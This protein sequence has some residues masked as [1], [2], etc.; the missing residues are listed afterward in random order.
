MAATD[1]TSSQLEELLGDDAE[2]PAGP[3]L[4]DHRQVPALPAGPRLPGPHLRGQRPLHADHPQPP[5]A[6]RQ[7]PPGRH[8]LREHPARSTRAS[9]TRAAPASAPTRPTSTPRTWSS[10]RSRA[11][12]TPWPPPSGVLGAVSRKYA[13]KIPFIVK[14]NHNELLTY[15]NTFDQVMFGSVQRAYDL[16]AAGVGATIYFGSEQSRRQLVEIVAGLRGG[17][18]RWACSPC[19][20]ATCATTTS[21]T[22]APTTTLAADL[23]GQ[24][25]H[26]GVTI[27]A[28][29]IKQKLPE[30][31]GGFERHRAYG[32]TNAAMYDK[33]THR[34]PD[35]PDPLPAGQLLHGPHRADQQ[36]RRVLGRERP[37]RGRA[38]RRDQQARRRHG[39]DLGPQGLPAADRR[40]HR[41]CST[42]SRTCTSIRTSN[43][44][45]YWPRKRMSTL[46]S[47]ARR[48]LA[49]SLAVAIQL[50][51]A[52]QLPAHGDADEH[53]DAVLLGQQR[54]QRDDRAPPRWG[55]PRR[56]AR[57]RRGPRRTSR[58]RAG[59]RPGSAAARAP[60]P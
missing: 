12:A 58:R 2:R 41:A 30:N 13:H 26:L 43:S 31:N 32:K 19:S 7:R 51:L 48:K 53:A 42:R 46:F 23:T 8:R 29:I 18:P 25:N 1:T 17:P 20:G 38:H 3:H 56:C 59:P 34:Q 37:G 54:A 6:G 16:G 35:R 24:A 14:L 10:W 45:Q 11:A 47:S 52:R 57:W 33:L 27:E 15:P 44:K 55:G 5:V 36:R 39:A 4:P 49:A 9:S 21:R 50:Q 28:D 60:G 40:G 22:T